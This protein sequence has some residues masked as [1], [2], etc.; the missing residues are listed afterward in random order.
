MTYFFSAKIFEKDTEESISAKNPACI[1]FMAT[2][3]QFLNLTLN[4]SYV[5]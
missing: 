1:A 2:Q 3:N 4:S 5:N